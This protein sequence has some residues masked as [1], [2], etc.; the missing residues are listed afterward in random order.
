MDIE[1]LKP[2]TLEQLREM[3]GKP[4]WLHVVDHTVFSDKDDDFDGYGLV[5]SS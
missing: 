5:R 1:N 4:V 2:L 3:D